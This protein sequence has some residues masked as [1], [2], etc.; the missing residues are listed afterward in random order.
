MLT[1][2]L[3]PLS[4][5]IIMLGMGLSLVVNDFLRVFKYPKAVAIGLTNQ[6]I[7]LPIVGFLVASNFNLTPAFAVGIMII[8]A[9]PG[10]VTSNLITYVAKGDTA[11]SITMTALA[12]FVTVF[13]IPLIIN[14]GLV[15]FMGESQVIKLPILET[16]G[17]IIIITIFPVSLG[18]LLRMKKPAVALKMEKPSRIASTV[19]FIIVLVAVI[20]EA[21]TDLTTYFSELSGATLTLNI[22]TMALGFVASKIFRLDLKQSLSITIESGIQNGTLAIVIGKEILENVDFALPAGVYSILM[23]VTGGILMAYFGNRKE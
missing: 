21:W 3:L 5:F 18:M 14:Y 10:G 15:E 8:A 22:V 12:S 23:F 9:C 20:I 4:L 13:S 19:I 11:L 1:D 2:V 7:L 16:M 17:K 6:L